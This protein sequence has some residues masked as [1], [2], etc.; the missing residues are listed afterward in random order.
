VCQGVSGYFRDLEAT[1]K[2]WTEDGRY[3]AGDLGRLDEGGN[4]V[5]VGRKKDMIIRGGMKIYPIEIENIVLKHPKVLDVA[6][7]SMPDPLG[8]GKGPA[9]LSC[10]VQGRS[11][12]LR[13]WSLSGRRKELVPLNCL[14]DSNWFRKS[15]RWVVKDKRQTRNK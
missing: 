4:L 11:L 2:V 14:K 15:R 7:V 13:I 8:W 3:K 6:V 12:H 5:V 1:M 10:L 9:P